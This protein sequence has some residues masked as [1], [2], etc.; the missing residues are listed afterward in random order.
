MNMSTFSNITQLLISLIV[1]FSKIYSE[2]TISMKI[3]FLHD[4]VHSKKAADG[5]T[6]NQA[7]FE[8]RDSHF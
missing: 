1:N 3:Q 7:I 2:I 4:I 6:Q 8:Y 5:F